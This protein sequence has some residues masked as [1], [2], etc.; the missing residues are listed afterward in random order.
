VGTAVRASLFFAFLIGCYPALPT[1]P[2]ASQE[3]ATPVVVP[4]P[5][6]PARVDIIG[7]PPVGMDNPVWVD[8]QWVFRGRRWTWEPG[9]WQTLKPKS[10]YAYPRVVRRSDGQLVWFEGTFRVVR[11]LP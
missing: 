3:G 2:V 9:E 8:G 4:Y 5:P 10:A 6:P 1:P 11:G 7:D